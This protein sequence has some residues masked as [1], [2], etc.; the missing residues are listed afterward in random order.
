MPAADPGSPTSRAAV[1]GDALDVYADHAPGGTA[2]PAPTGLAS[3]GVEGRLSLAEFLLAGPPRQG[4]ERSSTAEQGDSGLVLFSTSPRVQPEMSPVALPPLPMLLD[5]PAALGS[6]TAVTAAAV[7]SPVSAS[8]ALL[9]SQSSLTSADVTPSGSPRVG[10]ATAC[11]LGEPSQLLPCDGWGLPTATAAT[12]AGAPSASAD[13]V[14]EGAGPDL[15]LCSDSDDESPA[16]GVMTAG[17]VRRL[18]LAQHTFARAGSCSP[19]ASL[20]AGAAFQVAAQIPAAVSAQLAASLA[21]CHAAPAAISG[22]AS[23]MQ[24]CPLGRV[25]M[26]GLPAL[27]DLLRSGSS[28]FAANGRVL[29]LRQFLR[30]DVEPEVWPPT[31][32][33]ADALAP[34]PSWLPHGTALRRRPCAHPSPPLTTRR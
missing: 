27:L 6:D 30:P 7:D 2:L 4:H 33:T 5:V 24:G 32:R 12:A 10:A 11:G 14:S 18:C 15:L 28:A 13:S 17:G 1:V 23:P 20:T 9:G 34:S 21:D 31:P 3:P 22:D 8:L 16:D 29:R 26:P 19:A 25:T